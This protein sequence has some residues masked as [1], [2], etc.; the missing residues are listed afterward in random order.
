MVYLLLWFTNTVFKISLGVFLLFFC[1]I[2]IVCIG[3]HFVLYACMHSVCFTPNLHQIRLCCSVSPLWHGSR[4]ARQVSVLINEC[5]FTSCMSSSKYARFLF[6][7]NARAQCSNSVQNRSLRMGGPAQKQKKP[8]IFRS[9]YDF[10]YS[11][12]QIEQ[13]AES[14]LIS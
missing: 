3:F 11:T 5:T 12:V 13:K 8:P 10:S 4:A 14:T 9:L 7:S 6:L 2:L 1:L